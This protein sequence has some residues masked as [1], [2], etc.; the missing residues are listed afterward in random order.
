MTGARELLEHHTLVIRDGRVVDVLP[1]AAAAQK[2]EPRVIAERPSHLLMPGLVNAYTRIGSP[3]G[4]GN[5]RFSP[6]AALACIANMLRSG[7]TSFCD[8]GYFPSDS[9][10]TALS[11]GMRM[12]VGLPVAEQPTGWAQNAG[13]YLT[14]ALRLRDEYKGHPL[15]STRFAPLDFDTLHDETLARMA[16][17][18]DELDAGITASLR[19]N[20][21]SRQTPLARL[22]NLGLLSPSLTAAHAQS[23][24]FEPARRSSIGIALCLSSSLTHGEPLPA[25]GMLEPANMRLSLG[26]DG[27][28]CGTQDLWAEIRLLALS[29]PELHPWDVIAA[30]TRGGAAA[31]GLDAE[32]GTLEGNKWADL[33]CVDL[34]GPATQ[35]LTDP[36]RQLV[37]GGGRDLVSDTWIAGRQLYFDGQFTRLDWPSIADRLN[38]PRIDL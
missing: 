35:P 34:G 28:A 3:A 9:A 38:A 31:L 2:Y 8:I 5:P 23:A 24:D 25:R 4:A 21:R 13:E 7:I 33:C 16:T 20:G 26:S 14:R 37:H 10:R 30:A 19:S 27:E 22:E 11:Q 29:S 6:D 17:L 36:L 15:I 12:A 1:D 32:I 18:V